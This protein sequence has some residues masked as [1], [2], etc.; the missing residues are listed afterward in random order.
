MTYHTYID[1]KPDGTPFY[2]GVG[3]A[4]RIKCVDRNDLHRNIR[5]KYP[6]WT[7]TV[8]ETSDRESCLEFEVFL[9]SE[10]GRRDL[11]TGPLANMTAGGEGA[12]ETVVSEETRKKMSASGKG[13][14]LSTECVEK[15]RLAL[16][17]KKKTPEQ[18]EAMRQRLTG[19]KQS[20]EQRAITTKINAERARLPE[21]RQRAS[22][23]F[24]KLW[25]DPVFRENILRKRSES[26][27]DAY[28]ENMAKISKAMFENPEN[29][30][31]LKEAQ[32]HPE[33]KEHLSRVRKNL[34]WI[35]NGVID[36]KVPSEK[37]DEFLSTGWIRGR[38]KV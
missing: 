7:R 37:L 25:A 17:G 29:I 32:S 22:D 12:A 15:I 36:R 19:K 31:K 23:N 26:I 38:S 11:G 21:S 8:I 30:R 24:K 5:K 3:N 18:I 9:I 13:K 10:I 4:A 27:T 1:R 2:V 14:I 33:V 28:R 35:T 16:T 20:D 34:K 6:N